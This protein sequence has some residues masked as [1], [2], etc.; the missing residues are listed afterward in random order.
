MPAAVPHVSLSR[1]KPA[2]SVIL[3]F[4]L[5]FLCGVTVGALAMSLGLHRTMHRSSAG[6]TQN[7][8]IYTLQRWKQEL[9][10]TDAQTAQVET[11][12]DDFAKY[13]DNVLADG[14]VRIRQI[15]DDQQKVKFERMLK[16]HR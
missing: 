2:A 4:L 3:S 5:V 9:N 8:K 16:D 15:L 14:N 1:P 6:W 13:Y 12:L 7:G 10:L 11:I